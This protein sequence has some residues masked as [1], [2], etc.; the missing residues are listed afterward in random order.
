MDTHGIMKRKRAARH[1]RRDAATE[2]RVAARTR[3]LTRE[4]VRLTLQAT[5][6]QGKINR[7]DTLISKLEQ[8]LVAQSKPL[9]PEEA[10]AAARAEGYASDAGADSGGEA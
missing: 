5:Y 6:L 9:T 3:G 10:D 2:K 1:A 4:V 7:R 8:E